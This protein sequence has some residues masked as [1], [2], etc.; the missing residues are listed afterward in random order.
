[1]SDVTTATPAV[2]IDTPQP[3]INSTVET[4]STPQP[5]I[6][7]KLWTRADVKRFVPVAIHLPFLYDTEEEFEPWEFKL[8][9]ALSKEQDDKREEFLSLS[10]FERE[11]KYAKNALDE[12]CDLLLELPTG[13]GDINP[14]GLTVGPHN[15]G[16]IFRSYIEGTTD[17]DARKQLDEIV[18]AV[19]NQYWGVIAPRPFRR[20]V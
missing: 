5:P 18:L 20:K 11:G 9:F 2:V 17:P 4:P 6:G 15:A 8:R 3:K 7:K 14:E 12:V 16:A 10:A 13:F 19:S 1:M